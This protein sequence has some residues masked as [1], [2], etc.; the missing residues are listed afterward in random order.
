[1]REIL[2]MATS[3]Q[4][5]YSVLLLGHMAGRITSALLCFPTVVSFCVTPTSA[6]PELLLNT[7]L[8]APTP[9]HMKRLSVTPAKNFP[10]LLQIPPQGS[11]P[12]PASWPSKA[13]DDNQRCKNCF[14]LTLF[15]H[16]WPWWLDAG[17]LPQ[18]GLQHV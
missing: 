11:F 16:I 14:F 13:P 1:M 3:C 5:N 18:A 15:Q 12:K 6:P 7:H 10:S 8:S 9:T 17:G 2:T 4:P